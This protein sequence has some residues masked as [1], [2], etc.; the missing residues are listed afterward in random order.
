ME[1]S[2]T[3]GNDGVGVG[4]PDEGLR[5]LVALDDETVEGGLQLGDGAEG[6]VFL[7]LPGQLGEEALHGVQPG[8]GRR[9]EVKGPARVS[10]EPSADLRILVSGPRGRP[11]AGPRTGS[12][13]E[14]HVHHLPGRDV[15]L[16][17][18]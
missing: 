14:D 1:P 7:A 15:A 8:A 12:V 16:K 4:S 10:V 6:A 3:R 9:R 2:G 11:E 17:G 5:A 13:V 18:V